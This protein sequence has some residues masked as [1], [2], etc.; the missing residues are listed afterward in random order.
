MSDLVCI[1]HTGSGSTAAGYWGDYNCDVPFHTL[2]NLFQ[3]LATIKDQVFH[4]CYGG[5]V[6]FASNI[7]NL[8]ISSCSV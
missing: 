3:Y 6:A 5:Y 8:N 1:Y 4:A 7:V 2:E